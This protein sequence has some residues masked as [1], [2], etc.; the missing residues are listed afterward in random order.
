MG[1]IIE[2]ENISLSINHHAMLKNISASLHA[3]DRIAL[4]GPSG[5]GKSLCLRLMGMLDTPTHGVLLWKQQNIQPCKVPDYRQNVIYLNQK[6]VFEGGTVEENLRLPFRFKS[7]ASKTY[8]RSYVL[9]LLKKLGKDE[10]FL[11][12]AIHV[13]SGGESQIASLLRAMLLDPTALLLDEATSALDSESTLLA[14]KFILDW[15]AEKPRERG[16][17]WI[18]HH[19]SQAERIANKRWQM[20]SGILSILP[21]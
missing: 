8:D 15:Q 1:K 10:S 21:F 18:T 2:L 4:M 16:F 14:E 5:S 11:Q 19:E 9:S 12:K 20:N 7:H 17:I 13:L 3:G 6:S